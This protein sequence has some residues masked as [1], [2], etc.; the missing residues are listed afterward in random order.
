MA[1]QEPVRAFKTRRLRPSVFTEDEFNQSESDK[2]SF[3][4]EVNINPEKK[5]YNFE[6]RHED[7][8]EEDSS[9][10]TKMGRQS[11]IV[12]PNCID[13][14]VQLSPFAK[15]T[16]LYIG[17]SDHDLAVRKQVLQ[18]LH[19]EKP[20][21]SSNRSALDYETLYRKIKLTPMLE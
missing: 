16:G 18:P 1:L 17:H 10:L 19:S 5:T 7:Y 9:D 13:R 8:L 11:L 3:Y 12:R 15:T 2:R 6:E 4:S 20:M 14:Q 21:M